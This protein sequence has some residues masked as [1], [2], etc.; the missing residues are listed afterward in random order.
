MLPWVVDLVKRL[1]RRLYSDGSEFE[2]L[3]PEGT[4]VRRLLLLTS[5]FPS[6]EIAAHDLNRSQTMNSFRCSSNLASGALPSVNY[7][8]IRLAESFCWGVAKNAPDGGSLKNA[9]IT[10]ML[11]RYPRRPGAYSRQYLRAGKPN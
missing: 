10:E 2:L 1:P 6:D 9:A 3:S 4:K 5:R 8:T 7:V 11:G